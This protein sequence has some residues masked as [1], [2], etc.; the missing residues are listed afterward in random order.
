MPSNAGGFPESACDSV[1]RGPGAVPPAPPRDR[2]SLAGAAC[3]GLRQIPDG[4]G[5][6]VDTLRP[7]PGR[8]G[9]SGRPAR[10]AVALRAPRAQADRRAIPGCRPA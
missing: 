6:V 2:R 3:G 10:P 5:T 7:V 1:E 8:L 4:D 9:A